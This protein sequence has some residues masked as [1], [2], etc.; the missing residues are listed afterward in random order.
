MTQVIAVANQ[1]GGVGKTTV[2]VNLA[3]ALQLIGQH[4]LIVDSDPQGSARDWYQAS[5]NQ[6]S[7]MPVVVGVDRPVL[8]TSL[9]KLRGSFDTILIDGAAKLQDM[10]VSAIKAA[11]FVLIPVQPSA[12]D[13]WAAEDLV[14]L[15]KARQSVTEGRPKAAFLVSRQI[16]GTRLASDADRALEALSLPILTARTTQRVAYAECMSTG[17]TVLDLETNGQAASEIKAI[18]SELH[19]LLGTPLEG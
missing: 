14:E 4:V 1:K 10:T 7:D 3:R 17:S 11:D 12:L 2:A 13:I 6:N 5:Q 16:V 15:I 19:T 9:K 18:V 8:E